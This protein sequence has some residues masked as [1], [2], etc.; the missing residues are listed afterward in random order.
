MKWGPYPKYKDSGVEWLGEVPEHWLIVPL[1]RVTVEKCDGP[2][3]SGL[4]SEHYTEGGV[5]V[6]RLQNIRS[7]SFDEI[8]KAYVET[9][10][11]DTELQR[12]NVQPG[13]LLIAGL[14]DENHAVGRC[15]V[16]PVEIAPAMVKADCFRF[17]LDTRRCVPEFMALQLT[18]AAPCD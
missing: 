14:G 16:A 12:H 18:V 6:I 11:F 1:G 17:R 7:A 15:C 5:R 10:Y 3:G 8:D 13:D 2:F 4:K 9:T